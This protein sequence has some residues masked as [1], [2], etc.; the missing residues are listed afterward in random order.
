MAETVRDSIKKALGREPEE[1]LPK[2][3]ARHSVMKAAG[4]PIPPVIV[5]ETVRESVENAIGQE[6]EPEYAKDE[7]NYGMGTK[8]E[9]CGKCEHYQVMKKNGCEL[10]KGFIEYEYWCDKYEE[11]PDEAR[12]VDDQ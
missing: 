10:V 3:S 7:V 5:V 12:W 9:Y 11:K 6:S 1:P 8:T 4:V 2:E